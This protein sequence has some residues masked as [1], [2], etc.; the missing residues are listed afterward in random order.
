[1]PEQHEAADLCAATYYTELFNPQTNK[2][3]PYI[4]FPNGLRLVILVQFAMRTPKDTLLFPAVLDI[5]ARTNT[6]AAVACLGTGGIF[7]GTR[8]RRRLVDF[9]VHLAIFS[10]IA[11]YHGEADVAAAVRMS[12]TATGF[13]FALLLHPHN[14]ATKKQNKNEKSKDMRDFELHAGIGG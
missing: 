2:Y 12:Y 3:R 5:L 13:G 11:L 1:M 9:T 4:Q 6:T 10:R 14:R 7:G 8:S